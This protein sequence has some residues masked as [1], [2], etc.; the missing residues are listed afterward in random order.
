MRWPANTDILRIDGKSGML[1]IKD[2]PSGLSKDRFEHEYASELLRFSV[3]A[4]VS[5][6][7]KYFHDRTLNECFKLLRKSESALP[8]K[9]RKLEL[10]AHIGFAVQRRLKKNP[11]SRPGNDLKLEL[12]RKLHLLTF[13]NSQGVS[14]CGQLMGVQDFWSKV[15][16]EMGGSWTA[17]DIQDELECWVRRRNQIV[18]EADLERKISSKRYPL[19]DISR[20]NA[21]AAI[22]FFKDFIAAVDAV[23]DRELV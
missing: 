5:A 4:A 19:R 17:K 20:E 15:A 18:H 23:L 1:I 11:K 21:E 8:P 10:P 14:H 22:Q 3:V 13:Q 2:P 9:L 16:G 6:M 7:D 12:Q